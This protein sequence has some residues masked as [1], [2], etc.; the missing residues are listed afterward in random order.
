ML[1]FMVVFPNADEIAFFQ[2]ASYSDAFRD[3]KRWLQAE[4]DPEL[5]GETR[6]H[7]F[8]ANSH[9]TFTHVK[10][11]LV[12]FPSEAELVGEIDKYSRIKTEGKYMEDL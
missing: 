4:S 8:I 5:F 12:Q 3:A 9:G 11:L 10:T 1:K 6:A 7:L 2:R